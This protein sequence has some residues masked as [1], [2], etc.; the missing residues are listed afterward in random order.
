[1]RRE[2]KKPVR[3]VTAG[4]ISK[5][6]RLVSAKV[7][8]IVR[9][10]D[11]EAEEVL[12]NCEDAVKDCVPAKATKAS[13]ARVARKLAKEGVSARFDATVKKGLKRTAEEVAEVTVEEA[14]EAV[15]AIVDVVVDEFEALLADVDEVADTT[16]DEIT[17][18]LDDENV[19]IVDIEEAVKASIEKKLNAMGVKAGLARK[20]AKKTARTAVRKPV[21]KTT[22][23]R[24]EVKKVNPILAKARRKM[25]K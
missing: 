4:R 13:L 21:R 7:A 11:E 9:A 25:S 3:K 10:F 14:Q 19:D 16:V 18:E 15:D 12:E 2:I 22:A 6:D 24:K 20:H 5:K 17:D 1:M 8:K 23:T